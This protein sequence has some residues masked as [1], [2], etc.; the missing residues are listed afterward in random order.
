MAEGLLRSQAGRLGVDVHSHSAG[1]LEGG[2]EASADAV[3]VMRDR[4]IDNSQ[5]ESRQMTATMIRD[6]DLVIAMARDHVREA[7]LL[8]PDAFPRVYTLKEFVRR[9]EQAGARS[10]G[11]PVGEW[12]EKV[13]AGRT[14]A[15]LLGSSADDDVADPIG[16]PRV[17]Y[18]RTAVEIEGLVSRLVAFVWPAGQ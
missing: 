14:H 1:L 18:E 9:A 8:V 6:A 10:P 12:V 3:A 11:Q 16:R 15:D 2:W 4:G 5:H 7:V 13:H 17:H